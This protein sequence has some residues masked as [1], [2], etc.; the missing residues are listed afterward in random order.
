[1]E[2]KCVYCNSNTKKMYLNKERY[3]CS[4]NDCGKTFTNGSPRQ[5]KINNI[6]EI[7]ELHKEGK[8][9]GEIGKIYNCDPENIR[10]HLK[11][12]GIDTSLKLNNIQCIY[13]GGKTQKA[14]KSNNK[15]KCLCV[16]CGKLFNESI[17]E[18]SVKRVIIKK[19]KHELIKK[20]Y[21]VDMLSTT[22]IAANLGL[23]ATGI[24]TILKL[25]RITRDI[26]E[27]QLVQKANKIGLTCDEYIARLPVY[28]R[29]KQK[30][31]KIT[32]KQPI[33]TLP[34]FFN[35]RG[36]N[37]VVGAYQLDHRYS[38]LEGFKNDVLPEVI[39]NIANLEFISWEENIKKGSKCSITLKE[40]M[41]KIN[42]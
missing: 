40:L 6:S 9:C 12:N 30:V 26:S 11:K 19:E 36:K 29:Y 5:I 37:G 42:G 33:N 8:S 22:E 2:I 18:D 14:G 32:R 34:N 38:T 13:C 20:L 24:Q 16:E 35:K 3:K 31:T 1:M 28:K 17:I 23:T 15:Q 10:Y 39:G 25:Y 21:L 41:I 4:S 27:A 7:I